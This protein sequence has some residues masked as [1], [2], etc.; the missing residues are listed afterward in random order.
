MSVSSGRKTDACRKAD[1]FIQNY[2]RAR[3]KSR[4]GQYYNQNSKIVWNGNPM[5]GLQFLNLS[6]PSMFLLA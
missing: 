5:N 3:D 4:L 1:A 6:L 2:Y